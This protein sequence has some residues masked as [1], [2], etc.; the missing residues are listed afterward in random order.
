[1]CV[2]GVEGQV[3]VEEKSAWK[4]VVIVVVG[5][6]RFVH[7]KKTSRCEARGV[8][9]GS[10][11]T[12]ASGDWTDFDGMCA[13]GDGKI[14]FVSRNVFLKKNKKQT[15]CEITPTKH[16]MSTFL[17]VGDSKKKS[18]TRPLVCI[19]RNPKLPL[20]RHT[21]THKQQYVSETRR[22]ETCVGG[23]ALPR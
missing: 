5:L 8:R 12:I 3:G 20:R 10:R 21:L 17:H 15:G 23:I 13:G 2:V 19:D 18:K 7:G 11:R 4:W 6:A 22:R 1:M 16:D 9:V 14:F